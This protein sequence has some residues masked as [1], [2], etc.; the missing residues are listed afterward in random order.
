M[1]AKG[2]NQNQ[3]GS[4]WDQEH[5]KLFFFKLELK[6]FQNKKDQKIFQVHYFQCIFLSCQL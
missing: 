2:R 5:R 1:P 6:P 3:K 4:M